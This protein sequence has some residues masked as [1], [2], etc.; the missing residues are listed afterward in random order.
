MYWWL[1]HKL[2]R[3]TM[4]KVRVSEFLLLYSK[5]IGAQ[6]TTNQLFVDGLYNNHHEASLDLGVNLK[7]RS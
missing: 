2:V 6:E 1:Q 3:E 4:D 5:E 7:L